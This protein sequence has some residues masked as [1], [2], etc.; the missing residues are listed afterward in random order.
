MLT[1]IAHSVAL[2]SVAFDGHH[3]QR[4][5][6]PPLPELSPG[7]GAMMAALAPASTRRP[8]RRPSEGLKTPI[9]AFELAGPYKPRPRRRASPLPTGERAVGLRV[10]CG[11]ARW[12]PGERHARPGSWRRRESAA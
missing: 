12:R 6:P 8:S 11:A 7:A 9:A 5:Q 3:L 1:I 4:Q 10:R 2:S